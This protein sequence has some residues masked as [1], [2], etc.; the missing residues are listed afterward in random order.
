M[1][2][3]EL[4]KA[5]LLALEIGGVSGIV[6][7]TGGG[8]IENPPRV[9]DNSISF[10]L[11]CASHPLPPVFRWLRD[12]GN[13]ELSELARTFNCGIGFIIYVDATKRMTF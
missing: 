3:P 11:D 8:L 7:V 13:M 4:P 9:F 6:H 12:N 5:A 10:Q 1:A 2:L